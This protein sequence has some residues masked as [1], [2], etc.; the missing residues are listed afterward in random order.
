[1]VYKRHF[2]NITILAMLLFGGI[3]GISQKKQGVLDPENANEARL[4][5]LQPPDKV[6]DAIGVRPGMAVAEIGAGRG[7]YVV[8]LAVRVGDKGKA[9]LTTSRA[10]K[11]SGTH[12]LAGERPKRRRKKRPISPF[13]Q[14][15]R[16][17]TAVKMDE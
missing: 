6:M 13:S 8:H 12:A 1:M 15:T 3:T 17:G 4:N 7:R 2:F 11:S 9:R 14:T 5:K 16:S 10:R